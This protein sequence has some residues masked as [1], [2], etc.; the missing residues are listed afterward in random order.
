MDLVRGLSSM[1]GDHVEDTTGPGFE[2]VGYVLEHGLHFFI[3]ETAA[4][5]W[6][7][8]PERYCYW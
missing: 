6:L 4:G 8:K 7:A 2:W 5:C 3:S 1:V